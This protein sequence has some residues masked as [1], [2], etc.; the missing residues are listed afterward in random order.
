MIIF[1]NL[2]NEYKNDVLNS[3]IKE[4]CTVDE[5]YFIT[6]EFKSNGLKQINAYNI[7]EDIRKT[8]NED[9]EDLIMELQDYVSGFCQKKFYIWDEVLKF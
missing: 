3:I 2:T 8:L 6:K 1:L 9:K 5:L 4:N 7:L